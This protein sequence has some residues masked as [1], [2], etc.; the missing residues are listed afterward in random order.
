M[1]KGCLISIGVFLILLFGFIWI[2][3]DAFEPEYYNVELDQRIGGT[4]ICDVTYNADH[5]S[6]S[7]MIAYKYRDVND[8]TYKIG[9]GSYD[10]REWKKDEQLIQ[11]GKWLILKTG[12][13]HDSDKVFIG[14]LEAKKWKE[15]EF[16]AAS[17]EK[18]ST[19]N[20]EKIH[21]LPGWLPSEAFVSEIKDGKIYVIYEYR[22]NEKNTKATEKRLIE[23]EVHKVA[24]A[25]KM[26]RISLIP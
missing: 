26:K 17:I 24:G 10:G 9:Y 25:P 8:S 13:Y 18:D 4:L 22:V 11:Y 3:Q 20:L 5:H 14:D 16:S 21:S 23:Y 6:W 12:N 7:Y 19:W 2:L 15:F 1:Q